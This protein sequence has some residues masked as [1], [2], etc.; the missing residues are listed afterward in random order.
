[1]T[2]SIS[3]LSPSD[4]Q[5]S[6]PAMKPM[7]P[8]TTLAI[9]TGI[10][11]GSDGYSF[12]VNTRFSGHLGKNADLFKHLFVEKRN[13]S[14]W[15]KRK[16]LET[17]SAFEGAVAAM[18]SS[19]YA[20]TEYNIVSGVNKGVILARDPDG[21][22]Y[23]L[24]LTDKNRY[25][26]MTNFDYP[27]HDIKEWFDPTSIKGL[28]HSRRLDAQKILDNSDVLTPELLFSV[29]NNDGVMA[30]DTIFQ[31]I[32]NVE[33]DLYNTSLPACQSC[34]DC[35][36]HAQCRQES[37]TC[38]TLREHYTTA[39]GTLGGFK[40]GCLPD[41]QCRFPRGNMTKGDED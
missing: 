26:I 17:H 22:A 38:C 37:E 32:I 19:P 13:C 9:L 40:C 8:Y 30:K 5:E 7:A 3:G 4:A 1:M 39:C 12:E 16:I 11:R 18:S 31:A 2:S 10:R 27:W 21:L 15:V 36:N 35:A 20:A 23:K 33:K 34:G 6:L 28:G 41:G 14:G 29:L 24:E 25:I